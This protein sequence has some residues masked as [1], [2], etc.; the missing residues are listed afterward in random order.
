MDNS[1]HRDVEI[2]AFADDVSDEALETAAGSGN[3]VMYAACTGVW[4]TFCNAAG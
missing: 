3:Q 1:E 2:D 4:S